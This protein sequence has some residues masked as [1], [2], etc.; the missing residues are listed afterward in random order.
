MKQHVT[1]PGTHGV[2]DKEGVC[3]VGSVVGDNDGETDG[4]MEGC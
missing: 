4:E 3:D 1:N 2:G